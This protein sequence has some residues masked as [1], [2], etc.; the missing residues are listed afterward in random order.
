MTI[1]EVSKKFE[2]SPD[3]LRYYER[4][5]IIP[6]VKRTSGGIR[7]YTEESC[8]WIEL[9]KCLRTAGVQIEAL[10]K[11]VSLFQEGDST[12]EERKKILMDQRDKLSEK[13]NDLQTSLDVLNKKIET[14]DQYMPEFE[15]D[16]KKFAE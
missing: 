8:R 12:V 14:Y 13:I 10:I 2:I 5:G 3:T 16:F 15:K 4:I 9:M 6:P 7:D 11:Y 1:A